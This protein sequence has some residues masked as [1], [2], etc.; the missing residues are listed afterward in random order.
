[1]FIKT[2]I[3]AGIHGSIEHDEKVKD[4]IKAIDEQFSTSDKALTSTMIIKF[5]TMKLTGV[6]GVCD[7]IMLMRD[8]SEV[9]VHVTM[10]LEN[11]LII[12]GRFIKIG[13]DF[14]IANVYAPC[15]TVGRLYL[16]DRLSALI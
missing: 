6:R 12:K 4:L 9:D 5:S 7:H 11:V 8:Y 15:D 16:W 14:A 10:S 2:K 3:S 1:M 13:F